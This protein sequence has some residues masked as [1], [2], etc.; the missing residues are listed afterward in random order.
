MHLKKQQ[1]K[2]QQKKIMGETMNFGLPNLIKPK[3]KF[4]NTTKCHNTFFLALVSVN[5]IF[6]YLFYRNAISIYF[7][8]KL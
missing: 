1:T 3:K 8:N 7:H 2:N 5:L 4:R 6:Y